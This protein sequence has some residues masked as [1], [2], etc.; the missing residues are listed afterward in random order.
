VRAHRHYF[1]F[2]KTTMVAN[3]SS[4]STSSEMWRPNPH[5]QR[6][7]QQQHQQQYPDPATI[8]DAVFVDDTV[9]FA[10]EYSNDDVQLDASGAAAAAA[11][12]PM[13]ITPELVAH[14]DEYIKLEYRKVFERLCTLGTT[15]K[16]RVMV[17]AKS[18]CPRAVVALDGSSS[19]D[20]QLNVGKLEFESFVQIVYLLRALGVHVCDIS[21]LSALTAAKVEQLRLLQQQ[22]QQY[23][24]DSAAAEWWG[25]D[26]AEDVQPAAMAAAEYD[27]LGVSP[28]PPKKKRKR[29]AVSTS[30]NHNGDDDNNNNN[31]NNAFVC[32]TCNKSYARAPALAQH[33]ATVHRQ[34]RPFQCAHCDKRFSNS[35][36]CHR[37]ERTHTGERPFACSFCP[38]AFT[39]SSNLKVHVKAKHAFAVQ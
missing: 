13:E 32:A 1:D 28:A 24:D 15:E 3:S 9:F 6:L 17:F 11:M 35:S 2:N 37:H 34:E 19:G 26:S 5:L 27:P 25:R 14:V 12:P 18:I 16:R 29:A 7:Q 31:N 8:G 30:K 4:S 38:K 10:P 21:W 36:N 33:I 23:I 39:Q 22:Q 20:M